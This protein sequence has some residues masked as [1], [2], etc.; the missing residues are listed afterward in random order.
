M[1]FRYGCP[2][3]S[4]TRSIELLPASSQTEDMGTMNAT[5]L[6]REQHPACAS[7]LCVE[8]SVRQLLIVSSATEDR[9]FLARILSS[10][11]C[12]QYWVTSV[13][14]AIDWLERGSA[15]VVIC[16]DR[17]PDGQW[18]E[19]WEELRRR[20]TPPVFIV[21]A[22]WSDA[23]LWAEVLNLGAYDVLVK[24]YHDGEVKRILRNACRTFEHHRN[25]GEPWHT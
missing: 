21:S 3:R 13:H 15:Q 19:L 17:L 16:D 22:G 9:R 14:E 20:P 12:P 5:T 24:P 7:H 8:D 18:Q 6:V 10:H 2:D 25:G 23:R 1:H 4:D 11:T